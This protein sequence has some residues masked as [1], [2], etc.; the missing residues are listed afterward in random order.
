[1]E[2]IKPCLIVDR[3]KFLPSAIGRMMFST[4]LLSIVLVLLHE[5]KQEASEA[6]AQ[7]VREQTEILDQR[8]G[9]REVS[10]VGD[11]FMYTSLT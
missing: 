3:G 8:I 7:Q 11:E 9:T 4:G 6:V 1:M 10:D 2:G 5:L